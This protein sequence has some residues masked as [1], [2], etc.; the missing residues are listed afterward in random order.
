[1]MGIDD[2]VLTEDELEKLKKA[3]GILENLGGVI[4]ALIFIAAII[5]NPQGLKQWI[6]IATGFSGLLIGA[7]GMA[8]KKMT[9]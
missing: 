8:L 1:M 6:M 2:G 7:R 4:I 5:Y 9:P 3:G